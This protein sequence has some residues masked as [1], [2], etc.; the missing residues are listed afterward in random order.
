MKNN[1]PATANIENF[2]DAALSIFQEQDLNIALQYK[3]ERLKDLL[4]DKKDNTIQKLNTAFNNFS[5]QYQAR[6]KDLNESTRQKMEAAVLDLQAERNLFIQCRNTDTSGLSQNYKNLEYLNGVPLY[7]GDVL[8]A[9]R[10]GGLYQHFSIYAGKQQVIHYAA[11]QGDF[12]EV[13]S[14]HQAP[15]QEF[16]LDSK[17]IYI[18]DF[19]Q[20]CGY[21]SIRLPKGRGQGWYKK[22]QEEEC[23]L[24]TIIRSALYHLYSAE[25]TVARARS[26]I[27]E[28]KYTIPFNNCEHFAIWCKTGVAESYQINSLISKFLKEL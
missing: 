4:S 2:L 25:E 7:T 22:E 14:I 6:K 19:P 10:N 8:M 9:I 23:S 11:E 12:G 28:T 20:Q 27:G 18:L 16:Q 1:E 26:R 3:Q 21:P 15:F 24:F 13:L 17:E 5:K